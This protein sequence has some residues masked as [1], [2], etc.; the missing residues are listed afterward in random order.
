MGKTANKTS[1]KFT[2]ELLRRVPRT[3]R[4]TAAE[5][6]RQLDAIGIE[7][8]ERAIRMLL[9][10]LADMGE[11]EGDGARPIG[12]RRVPKSRGFDAAQMAE[13]ESL[14][15]ML[16]Q[17]QL[18]A[19]LPPSLMQALEGFFAQ[20]RRELDPFGDDSLAKQWLGKVHVSSAMPQLIPPKIGDGVLE[21]VSHALY[22]NL[23]LRVRYCNAEGQQSDKRVQPLGLVQHGVRLYLVALVD[24]Y[25]QP[26][27]LALHR[28]LRVK[29]GK[30][31]F[32]RPADFDLKRFD[33]QGGISH[34]TGEDVRLSFRLARKAAQHV[35]ESPLTADQAH[36]DE[37]D[38]VRFSAVYP[39]SLRLD[40]WLWSF[41]PDISDVCKEP[42]G[43]EA[44]SPAAVAVRAK[45]AKTRGKVPVARGRGRRVT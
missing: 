38:H 19:L 18:A 44:P 4:I 1:L 35:I 27:G 11:V 6:K 17:K 9:D 28:V 10:T 29:A 36:V 31:A 3:R 23:P 12:Y 22:A 8:T 16:T 33:D 43:S 41:G 39:D 14:L 32:E 42:I 30:L 26:L 34:A 5:L 21:T 15:L 40:R 7:R 24:G 45:A 13:Q 37:G 2:L 25:E 20:A